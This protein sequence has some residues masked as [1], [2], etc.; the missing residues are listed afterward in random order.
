MEIKYGS[1]ASGREAI[2]AH[3][4]AERA[5]NPGYRVVDIGGTVGGWTAGY[6][7][8]VVDINARGGAGNLP[9]DIC[10]PAGWNLLD[11]YVAENGLF[12]YAIC[13]HTLEDIYNPALALERMP[14]IAGAGVITTP[15]L[16][17]E[18]GRPE[19]PA[20]LGYIHHRWIFAGVD[21]GILLAPKLGF[22]ERLHGLPAE[23]DPRVEEV[24]FHW[25]GS[26]QYRMFMDNYLGPNAG[27]VIS[28]YTG[29]IRGQLEVVQ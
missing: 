21:G 13:T 18:L 8:L 25:A 27:E 3:I 12:D 20:W 4:R 15:S 22:L 29:F 7:D 10:T 24:R 9:A 6:C 14:R 11:G 16:R 5:A 2:L 17:T 26:I 1:V 28:R 23:V 19:N